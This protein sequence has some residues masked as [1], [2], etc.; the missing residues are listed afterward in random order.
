M[1]STMGRAALVVSGGILLSRI[2]GFAREM[3]L[4]A[5]LGRSIDAD[6]YQAAFTIPDFLFFL[7]AGGYLTLTFV[8]IVSRHLAAGEEDEANRSFTAIARVV[9]GLMLIA[10]AVTM[11]WARPLTE[12]VFSDIPAERLPQLVGLVRIV[13][14]AQFFFVL[15]SLYTAVQYAHRRFLIPTLAPIVY[16]IAIIGGG[17]IS[18]LLG[19][20]GPEGFVLGALTGAIVGNFGLQWWGA[21]RL[22]LRWRRGTP[23]RHPS[24]AEYFALALPLMIGQSAVGLD[25]V[26]F[27]Y[28]GQF[29]PLGDIAA[30]NYARRLQM[31]P[32]GVIAQAAG[33][34]SYPFL[35][36]LFAEGRRKEM[37]A[38]VNQAVRSG[39]VVS[40]LAAAAVIALAVPLVAVAYQRGSFD[41]ADTLATAPLLA[42][43]GIAIPMWTAHQVY[44]RAFY[45]QR[46]M[47]L[48]VVVGTA[49]T[50]VA[51]PAYYF[52]ATNFAAVGVAATSTAVMSAYALIMGWLWHREASAKE[53]TRSGWQAFVA[54]VPAGAAA[55]AAS[56]A[57]AG[58]EP[59]D[60]LIGIV[61]LV[62]GGALAAAV[63]W[64]VLKMLVSPELEAVLRRRRQRGSPR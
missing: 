30:L 4:A 57:L 18:Y 7:M 2:L 31:V 36:R 48:P 64:A 37:E 55:W 51:L 6:L 3:V 10:T 32:V 39:L 28:F 44:T 56:R 41:A 22:G 35:A 14:P 50:V 52:S 42:I 19:E 29:A 43:Y 21:R 49:I 46:R 61:V 59:P 12:R 27:R 54:G 40:G 53:V 60:T 23:L 20:T 47:W 45:A 34:A 15:G 58:R 33:V 9:G 16:N 26:F 11:I 8:P 13:L 38:Q 5:L 1:S 62:V 25:E 63:Y 17:T 24:V